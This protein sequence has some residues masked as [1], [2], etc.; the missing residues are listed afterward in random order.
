MVNDNDDLIIGTPGGMFKST[1]NGDNWMVHGDL[2]DEIQALI[3]DD[4]G[5][6]YTGTYTNGVFKSEDGGATWIA[7]SNGLPLPAQVTALIADPDGGI[8]VGLYPGGVFRTTDGGDNWSEFNEGIPIGDD[9]S[10]SKDLSIGGF[11]HL[12]GLFVLLI[13]YAVGV[14]FFNFGAEKTGWVLIAAGLPLNPSTSSITADA[15]NQVFVGT[16][17]QGLYSG[18]DFLGVEQL[19]ADAALFEVS[20]VFPNPVA[21]KASFT[22]SVPQPGFVSATLFD[23]AGKEVLKPVSQLFNKGTYQINIDME[24]LPAGTYIIRV[25]SDQ[26]IRS[27]MCLKGL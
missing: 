8:L 25:Q 16:Y 10:G 23:Q 4:T 14:L 2:A 26:N 5:I 3:K 7:A 18:Q 13:V 15:E 1:D 24:G 22:V 6:M 19:T 11:W 9:E 21:D 27:L 12:F 17:H 20:E